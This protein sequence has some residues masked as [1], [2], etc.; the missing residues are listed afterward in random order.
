HGMSEQDVMKDVLA[1]AIESALAGGPRTIVRGWRVARVSAIRGHGWRGVD[2]LI[3]EELE[4]RL[5]ANG[6][7]IAGELTDP[8]RICCAATAGRHRL[9][10]RPA[11]SRATRANH[12]RGI[13][14]VTANV[15]VHV[16]PVVLEHVPHRVQ[17]GFVRQ[18]R[19]LRLRDA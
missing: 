10:D 15:E 9:V 18:V 5:P 19:M 13:L 12:I 2:Q 4:P 3:P 14:V 1:I 8:G 7:R 6:A 16:D 11:T 17:R